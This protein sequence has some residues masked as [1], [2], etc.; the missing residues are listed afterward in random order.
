M[1][2]TLPWPDSALNPNEANSSGGFCP[3]VNSAKEYRN[4]AYTLTYESPSFLE[5]FAEGEYKKVTALAID[6]YPPKNN[7]DTDGLLSAI[8]PGID[9]IF[10]AIHQNDRQVSEI[11]LVRHPADKLNPRVVICLIGENENERT[12][13]SLPNYASWRNLPTL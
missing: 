1:K 6:F 12:K 5:Y 9:G 7:R 4:K 8:K 10:D 13:T 11:M 2:I 3:R